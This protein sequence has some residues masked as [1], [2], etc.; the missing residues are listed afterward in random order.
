MLF[1]LNDI[2]TEIEAPEMR[3]LIREA[4]F[5]GDVQG[6]R[7]REAMELARGRLQ[8]LHDRGQV[9]DQTMVDD[10]AALIIAKTGANAALFPV[11]DGRVAEAR[12]TI[13]PE[14]ILAAVRTR[15]AEG[16]GSDTSAF[17]TRAA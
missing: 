9:P 5:G 17:W 8:A 14:A 16:R 3:L 4:V 13:L 12:L 6:L 15:F 7:P 1:L 2:V 10:L 11:H